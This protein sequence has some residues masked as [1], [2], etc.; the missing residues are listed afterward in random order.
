MREGGWEGLCGL[1]VV[2]F[3]F[4]VFFKNWIFVVK[5]VFCEGLEIFCVEKCVFL[6]VKSNFWEIV[7]FCVGVRGSS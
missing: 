6:M 2:E 1:L 5:L 4:L 7:L 3:F